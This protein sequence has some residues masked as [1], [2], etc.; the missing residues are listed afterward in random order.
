M[1]VYVPLY[2]CFLH[3]LSLVLSSFHLLP[4]LMTP[5]SKPWHIS[6]GQLFS[7]DGL[8]TRLSNIIWKRDRNAKY[9]ALPH[10]QTLW[11]WDSKICVFQKP[12]RWFSCTLKLKRHYYRIYH[13]SHIQYASNVTPLSSSLLLTYPA[14]LCLHKCLLKAICLNRNLNLSFC[15]CLPQIKSPVI[16]S[17][18]SSQIHP[19]LLSLSA[20]HHQHS[21]YY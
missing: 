20:D 11:M 15:P 7:K 1:I 3:S 2:L 18:P 9:W 21:M 6:L 5:K 14:P 19:S 13:V 17:P 12:S 16:Q 10:N 8:P 4:I